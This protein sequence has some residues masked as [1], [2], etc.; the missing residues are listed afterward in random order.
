MKCFRPSIPTF[1]KRVLW[2]V[3]TNNKRDAGRR[4]KEQPLSEVVQHIDPSNGRSNDPA[5]SSYMKHQ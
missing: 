3:T 5:R 2:T 1:G 4:R